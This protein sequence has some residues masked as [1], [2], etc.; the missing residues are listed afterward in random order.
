[1]SSTAPAVGKDSAV[2]ADL[3]AALA[4]SRGFPQ[5]RGSRPVPRPDRP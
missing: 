4:R 5:H 1:M 2:V 3:W